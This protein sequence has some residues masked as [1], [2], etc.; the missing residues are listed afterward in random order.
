M[1]AFSASR[2][3]GVICYLERPARGGKGFRPL[4]RSPSFPWPQLTPATVWPPRVT[5]RI[6][7]AVRCQ[8]QPGGGAPLADPDLP[9]AGRAARCALDAL[10]ERLLGAERHPAIGIG[11][12]FERAAGKALRQRVFGAFVFGHHRGG[13][14]FEG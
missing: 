14:K 3:A 7:P 5:P 13:L 1:C 4:R 6:E 12:A 10:R 2:C 11:G 8:L 9:A